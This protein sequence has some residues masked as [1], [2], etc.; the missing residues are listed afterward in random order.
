[1]LNPFGIYSGIW[2]EVWLQLNF[3]LDGYPGISTPF[4]EES[5][6]LECH[7]YHIL[8]VFIVFI[9]YI[10]SLVCLVMCFEVFCF[11]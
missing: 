8:N 11:V 4:I 6:D 9:K 10:Y 1:M 5:L 7:I 3:F 2:C